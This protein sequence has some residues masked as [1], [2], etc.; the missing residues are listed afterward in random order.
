M[1]DNSS[2]RCASKY[3][4][5]NYLAPRSGHF[6]S[7]PS[8]PADGWLEAATGL[9]ISQLFRRRNFSQS[10][11]V[12]A[13]RR[14]H[15]CS[16]FAG[17]HFYKEF[18]LKQDHVGSHLHPCHHSSAPSPSAW[19]VQLSGSWILSSPLGLFPVLQMHRPL[20]QR[21]IP[22]IHVHMRWGNRLRSFHQVRGIY[23]EYLPIR[24]Q[25]M[26]CYPIRRQYLEY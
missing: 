25:Y 19:S 23:W 16:E 7:E 10:W 21:P 17:I 14:D 2:F 3:N 15:S 4:G 8:K 26:E 24:R 6:R 22:T 9:L 11:A 20:V 1:F 13:A 12:T 5:W 18:P